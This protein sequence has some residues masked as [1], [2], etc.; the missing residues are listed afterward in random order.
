MALIGRMAQ[1][2]NINS[3][4]TG[5]MATSSNPRQPTFSA[6]PEKVPPLGFLGKTVMAAYDTVYSTLDNTIQRLD[7]L[8]QS[9]FTADKKTVEKA[10]QNELAPEYLKTQSTP[11]QRATKIGQ[12][13][14]G[15]A[16]IGF[17]PV[18]AQ[19]EAAKQIPIIKYPAKLASYGFEKIGELGSYAMGKGVD[20]LPVS[21][22]T[23][24]TIKPLSEELGALVAQIVGIKTGLKVAKKGINLGKLPIS[25]KAKSNISTG[26]QA[27][28]GFSMTPFSTA[29]SLAS[30][31][32]A[33]KVEQK[34]KQGIEVTPEIGKQIVNEVKQEIKS[35]PLPDIKQEAPTTPELSPKQP[36]GEVLPAEMDKVQP[37]T[38]QVSGVA[39]QIK[40]KAIEKGL[41]D[42]GIT[43]LPEYD[44]STI[45]KQGEIGSKYTTEQLEE[46]AR[47]GNLPEGMKPATP[48]SILE[49]LYK[50]NPE[51][52]I[53]LAKSPLTS[54]ISES[55]SEVS[56]SRMREK[57]GT[58]ENIRQVQEARTK[59]A[60]QSA[61]VEEAKLKEV[62]K[63]S[64]PTKDA[65][66]EFVDSIKC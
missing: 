65:W 23:K 55:A 58:V 36:Q 52:L 51:K 35:Q 24:D 38:P 15:I 25:E 21:Q 53:E 10:K 34:Q 22:Q 37:Q 48:L 40:A 66:L 59:E 31:R 42:K 13:A 2:T 28:A 4:L 49:D 39:E 43:E 5:R 12:A 8:G 54:R 60:G 46:I 47:T 9:L 20:A 1:Q 26:A 44:A 64:K 11:L 3:G 61:R 45:K 6:A 19:I 33:F 17:L 30:A 62:V 18:T 50:N 63:K 56:L 27:I 7:Q 32:I 29:Y 16:N 57:G 14:V 41:A